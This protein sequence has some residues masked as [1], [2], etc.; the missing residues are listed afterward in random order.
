MDPATTRAQQRRNTEA[1]I[2]EAAGRLFAEAG[3]ERTTIRAIATAAATDPGLVMRY[4]GS[5][6]ELFARVAVVG[7]LQTIEGSP[8]QTAEL[9]LGA[10]VAKLEEE[11]VNALAAIRSMLTNPD[12][13]GEVRAA[14]VAQQRQAADH[15]VQDDA[16]LR[17]GLLGAVTL[18]VVI[19]RHLLHLD[20]LNDASPQRISA[21]LRRAFHEIAHGRP[22]TDPPI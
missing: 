19:G 5:K 10:L 9:L 20:G 16:D 1:R 13:A 14:M 22:E 17:A 15:L 3:Y 11:P 21:V 4:F 8:T 2:L 18:G 12:A 7:D 6:A